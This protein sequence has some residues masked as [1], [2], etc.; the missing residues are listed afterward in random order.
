VTTSRPGAGDASTAY[1]ELVTGLGEAL[2][3]GAPG[4]ALRF[5]A[6]TAALAAAAAA[7]SAPA[8]AD[9]PEGAVQVSRAAPRARDP[10][11]SRAA[12]TSGAHPT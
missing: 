1:V 6:D 9:I 5:T 3:G 7:A 4:G 11:R 10:C 8:A 12:D 2:V